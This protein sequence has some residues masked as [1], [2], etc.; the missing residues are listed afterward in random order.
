MKV[1]T[2]SHAEVYYVAPQKFLGDKRFAYTYSLSFK[3]KQ[4]DTDN[5]AESF[6]GDVILRGEW[7]DQLLVATLPRKPGK[8]LTSYKVRSYTG[9]RESVLISFGSPH[10]SDHYQNEREAGSE[11]LPQWQ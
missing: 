9:C 8:D 1:D 3:L 2:D 10:V 6:K 5:P 11:S 4:D 7:F